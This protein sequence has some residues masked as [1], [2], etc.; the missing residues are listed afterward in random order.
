MNTQSTTTNQNQLLIRPERAE[1][2]SAVSTLL[3]AA[4]GGTAEAQLV[5]A[6]RGHPTLKSLVAVIGG[7]VVGHIAFSPVAIAAVTV[8]GPPAEISAYGLAPLAV[9]PEH[10]CM[11]I[12]TELVRA[13]LTLM[14]QSGISVVVVL[15][16]PAYYS[17]FGFR[18]A[19]TFNITCKWEDHQDAFQ[20]WS[21]LPDGSIP[22]GVVAYL[23]EFDEV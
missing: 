8:A 23:P 2:Y 14:E 9:S 21:R 1:D 22:Q 16:D 18:P 3:H 13:G 17:R 20:V 10:Q 7:E 5:A 4:F 11:G 6:L 19:A 15:G 12:G